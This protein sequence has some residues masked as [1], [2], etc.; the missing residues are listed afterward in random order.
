VIEKFIQEFTEREALGR[1]QVE[2]ARAK[3]E[4]FEADLPKLE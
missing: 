3:I 2:E 1:K 4:A